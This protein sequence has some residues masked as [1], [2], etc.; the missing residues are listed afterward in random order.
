MTDFIQLLVAGVAISRLMESQLASRLTKDAGSLLSALEPDPQGG[1]RLDTRRV[2][3]RYHRP[4]SGFY[5]TIKAGTLHETSRSLWDAAIESRPIATGEVLR[6]RTTGPEGQ[7][8]LE[9]HLD[10]PARLSSA[11]DALE[12]AI[13]VSPTPAVA[14]PL[15]LGHVS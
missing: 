7:P 8:L 4:L 11:R 3:P 9:L 13:E 15:V 14:P 12:G 6:F 5:Y 10:D 2:S 1:L